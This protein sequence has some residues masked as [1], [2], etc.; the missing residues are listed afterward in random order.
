M[1]LLITILSWHPRHSDSLVKSWLMSLILTLLVALQVTYLSSYRQC[2]K[3]ETQQTML[4][5]TI[6]RHLALQHERI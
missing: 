5:Q 6:V 1:E 2:G 3:L 4:Q